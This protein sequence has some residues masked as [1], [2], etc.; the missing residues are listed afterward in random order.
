MDISLKAKFYTSACCSNKGP[1]FEKMHKPG[2]I[3]TEIQVSFEF[4]GFIAIIHQID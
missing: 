1:L 4:T 3:I 2:A